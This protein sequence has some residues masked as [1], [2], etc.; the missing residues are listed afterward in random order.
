MSSRAFQGSNSASHILS[1]PFL[2]P[3]F[4]SPLSPIYPLLPHKSNQVANAIQSKDRVHTPQWPR[5]LK[6]RS[7][8]LSRAICTRFSSVAMLPLAKTRNQR[9]NL[10]PLMASSQA[11]FLEYIPKCLQTSP[12]PRLAVDHPFT[13]RLATLTKARIKSPPADPATPVIKRPTARVSW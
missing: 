11:E 3:P 7:S 4:P 10:C 5:V 6:S 13:P 1:L 9:R 12:P 2:I 8:Q